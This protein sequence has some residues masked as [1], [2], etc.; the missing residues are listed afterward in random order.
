M[1]TFAGDQTDQVFAMDVGEVSQIIHQETKCMPV[2][3]AASAPA[4]S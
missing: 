4:S 1:A 2:V 3:P